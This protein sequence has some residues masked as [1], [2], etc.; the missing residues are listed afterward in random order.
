MQAASQSRIQL[1]GVFSFRQ[2]RHPS[3]IRA[4]ESGDPGAVKYA[5]DN[6]PNDGYEEI[7]SWE[8]VNAVMDEGRV[9]N[10]D[11][12]LGSTAKPS[13]IYVALFGN[14]LSNGVGN[15]TP[16]VDW[17]LDDFHTTYNEYTAYTTG[18]VADP[19]TDSISRPT[20][21][22]D[23]AENNAGVVTIANTT[24]EAPFKFT[25][26]YQIYGSVLIAGSALKAGTND[27]S[28]ANYLVAGTRFDN[29]PRTGSNGDKV[30]VLYTLRA[31]AG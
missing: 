22:P 26:N 29:A 2:F 10:L 30:T 28:S 12:W 4:L 31:N 27:T 1:G 19:T 17:V 16:A 25:D 8:S 6:L 23:A 20:W 9:K 3:M 14:T 13:A 21:S 18:T 7:D 5:L 24:A 15:H 11:V